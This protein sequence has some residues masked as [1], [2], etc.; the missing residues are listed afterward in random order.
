M[1]TYDPKSIHGKVNIAEEGIALIRRLPEGIQRSLYLKALAEKLDLQ[2]SVLHEMLRSSPKGTSKDRTKRSEGLQKSSAEEN[3]PKPEEMVV[4]LM[5]QYPE[6]IGRI[7]EEGVLDDFGSPVLRK[8]AE[9]DSI[10][11]GRPTWQSLG[12][13]EEDLWEASRALA[14]EEDGLERGPGKVLKANQKIHARRLKDQSEL[15]RK[16]KE[17]EKQPGGKGLEALL[18]ERQELLR[19][20]DGLRRKRG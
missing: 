10:R 13:P 7:S 2:E 12:G 11:R 16:I 15:L 9:K 5:T 20:E 1:R 14:L 17:A 6:V 3:F 19:K 8:M 18:L 4:R